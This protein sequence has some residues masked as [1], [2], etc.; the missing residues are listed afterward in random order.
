MRQASTSQPKSCPR[1]PWTRPSKSSHISSGGWKLWAAVGREKSSK[2]A[3]SPTIFTRFLGQFRAQIKSKRIP[4]KAC[5]KNV[6][7]QNSLKILYSWRRGWKYKIDP[8]ISFIFRN[9]LFYLS[10]KSVNCG[11][12]GANGRKYRDQRG[13]PRYHPPLKG[14]GRFWSRGP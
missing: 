10:K 3:K 14:F 8:T 12:H 2:S 7:R 6:M 11:R 5:L 1:P 9:P 13:L 4:I